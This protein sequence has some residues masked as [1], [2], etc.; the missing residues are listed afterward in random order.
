M[1]IYKVTIEFEAD[2]ELYEGV[3][4]FHALNRVDALEQCDCKMRE[5]FDGKEYPYGVL[6]VE[7]I[8]EVGNV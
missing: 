6:Q 7:E 4:T 2:G 3:R 8:G 1:N 5:A